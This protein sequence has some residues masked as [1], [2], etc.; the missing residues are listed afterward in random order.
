[1]DPVPEAG[2]QFDYFVQ[3]VPDAAVRQRILVENAARLYGF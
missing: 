3:W 2:V 1:M